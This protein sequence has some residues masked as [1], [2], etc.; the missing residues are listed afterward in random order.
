MVRYP[1]DPLRAV[2]K[3]E[4]LTTN[5]KSDTYGLSHPFALR[6]TRLRRRQRRP[7]YRRVNGTFYECIKYG[8]TKIYFHLLQ[9]VKYYYFINLRRASMMDNLPG[10]GGIGAP[11]PY[12]VWAFVS[13]CCPRGAF[14]SLK[15]P[16]RRRTI[17]LEGPFCP[18]KPI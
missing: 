16:D 12:W 13:I 1:F 17:F 10:A 11:R 3:V 8:F 18:G 4:P 9:V 5:G 15:H 2:S 7:G 6:F 14:T